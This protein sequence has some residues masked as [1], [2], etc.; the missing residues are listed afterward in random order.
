MPDTPTPPA[1]PTPDPKRKSPGPINKRYL[2]E[3]KLIRDLVTQAQKPDRTAALTGVEWD[4]AR[5]TALG[6]K[7]SGLEAA[8]LA[9]VG[10][11]QA[12]Q[13]DTAA[14]GDARKTMLAAI[15]PIRVGAKRK[16]R[17]GPDAAAGRSAYYVNEPTGVS[18]DRL[19]FI[20]DSML[21][22]LTPQAP[23]TTPEDTLP[24]VT[25]AAIS[26]LQTAH[27]A[28]VSADAE[29]QGT[30]SE[31]REAQTALLNAYTS[32]HQ[33]RLDLQLGADQVWTHHDPANAAIRR[34]FQIPPDRPMS[35]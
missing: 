2:D 6:E 9:A 34:D 7:A 3:I 17:N 4:G 18:L 30:E 32:A 23:A 13:L 14:E 15:H 28:Y 16:Y 35:E 26:T 1:P 24:G 27:D 10:R 20:A 8:A 21:R 5:V 25:A 12:R 33:E 29:Q 19:L 11:K 22:R 31:K